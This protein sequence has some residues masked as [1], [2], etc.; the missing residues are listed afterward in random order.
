MPRWYRRSRRGARG[1]AG[2]ADTRT[3]ARYHHG[4]L[5]PTLIDAAIRILETKGVSALTLRA[6]A[7]GAGVSQAAPYRHFADKASL[8]AAVAEEGFRALSAAMRAA[9]ART[10]GDFA[11]RFRAIGMAYVRFAV[12]QPARF[13]LMFGREVADRESH[14]ALRQATSDTFGMLMAGIEEGQKAGLI[15]EGDSRELSMAVWSMVHGLSALLVDGQISLGEQEL[16][17]FASSVARHLFLGLRR[18][19]LS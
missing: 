9:A 6:A 14:L 10:E 18:D 8:L 17:M 1:S 16:E 12:E 4:N 3:R 11:S 7:R 15:R 13:R 19:P 2:G 5:R